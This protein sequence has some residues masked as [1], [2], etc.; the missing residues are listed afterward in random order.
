M[1][2]RA[3]RI[4]EYNEQ[5]VNE[6]KAT[7]PR[8]EDGSLIEGGL[9]A[10]LARRL[11]EKIN[12][13]TVADQR[14]AAV[15]ESLTKQPGEDDDDDAGGL[16]LN[17]FG[18]LY[19]YNPLRLLKDSSGNIIEEERAPASFFMAELVRSSEHMRRATLWNNRKAR[20]VEFFLQWCAAERAK[21][22]PERELIWG[23]CAKETGIVHE[24]K[25]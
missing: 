14:A 21:G 22:R 12:L 7:L 3:K 23:N 1:S 18:D 24:K 5:L 8:N 16:Q 13:D 4:R 6:V 20:K 15:I 2:S 10:A 25:K 9:R 11:R 19:G 17:L